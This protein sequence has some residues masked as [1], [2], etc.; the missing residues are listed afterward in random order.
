MLESYL[1]ARD[2]FLSR[3][4]ATNTIKPFQMYPA[5]ASIHFAPLSDPTLYASTHERASFWSAKSFYGIDV[6][7]LQPDAIGH[8]FGQT[9]VGG[10]EPRALM[11]PH[12]SFDI[13]FTTVS[14]EALREFTV[15][16]QWT[17]SATGV[18]HGLAAW[19]DVQ[20]LG[21][22]KCIQLSTAPDCPRTHWHQV[23]LL[24]RN[25][26][27]LNRGQ[28]L[29]G[30]AHF[31]ANA[32]R[33]YNINVCLALPD[34]SLAMEQSFALHDQQYAN[35]SLTEGLSADFNLDY[36]NLYPTQI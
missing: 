24:F 10:V 35:M 19:F 9:V 28:I 8:V 13:D 26:L 15:P 16:L 7:A 31:L 30:E 5:L 27:A 32:H 21:S 17:I 34:E 14:I 11:A 23:R 29:S 2:K 6:S 36:L 20:F 4:P 18:C 3:D 33:S 22:F 1:Y 25:P 12:C